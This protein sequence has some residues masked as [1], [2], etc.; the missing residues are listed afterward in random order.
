MV[1]L[2]QGTITLKTFIHLASQQILK[3][4]TPDEIIAVAK[5][6]LDPKTNEQAGVCLGNLVI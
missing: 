3:V 6:L 4:T 2:L 1:L 5:K